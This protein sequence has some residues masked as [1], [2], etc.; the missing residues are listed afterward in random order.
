M[1]ET[2]TTTWKHAGARAAAARPNGK[3]KG[4]RG[5]VKGLCKYFPLFPFLFSLWCGCALAQPTSTGSGQ[6]YPARPVRMI[7]PFSAGGNSD[8]VGRLLAPG[9]AE[10]LGQNVIVENRP[11]A[12]GMIGTNYVAKATPDGHTLLVLTGAFTAVAATVKGLPYDA[13]RDFSWVSM[14]IT[15]PFVLVVRNESSLRTVSDYIAAAKKSPGKLVYGS[16]GTGSMFHLAA[17]LVNVMAGTETTHVPYKGGAEPMT[18][19]IGGRIDAIFTT[20]TGAF[21]HIEAKRVRAV[22]VASLERSPQL[23]NVPTLAETLPGYEVTSFAGLAVPRGTPPAVVARL[24]REVRAVL[25][26]PDVRRR[27]TDSGGE[28]RPTTPE[29]MR[30]HVEAEI[31]KW[32]RIVA[33]RKIEVN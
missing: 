2:T 10:R 7:A 19:L 23:P 20:L 1:T 33:E 5:K 27:L 14:V 11:G 30:R 21:P 4:E 9:L 13:V 12:G 29:E 3:A 31:A 18:D 16:V 25:D 6:A 28:V 22:A 17:E 15:Y 32:K 8:I 24:N 26:L